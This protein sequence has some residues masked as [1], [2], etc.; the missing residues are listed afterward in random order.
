MALAGPIANFLLTITAAV[1]IHVGLAAGVFEVP[2]SVN[3][4]HLVDAKQAGFATGL[5][6]FLSILF[7]LNLLLGT[8]NLLPVSP[9]DGHSAI[10]LLLPEG[11]FLRWLEFIRQPM[12][13]LVG[14]L[15]AWQ[16]FD[17][18]FW[19]VFG[20]GVRTLHWGQGFL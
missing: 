2:P 9:L 13:S 11:M 4:S 10:G 16:G 6:E 5:A 14:L 15:L 7:S 17:R 3:F 1:A 20:W 18:V 12:P 19:P 8:F